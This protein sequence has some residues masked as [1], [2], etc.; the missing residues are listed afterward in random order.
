MLDISQR[1]RAAIIAHVKNTGKKR[2]MQQ[3]K[4]GNK[5]TG[6]GGIAKANPEHRLRKYVNKKYGAK[7]KRNKTNKWDIDLAYGEIF[8]EELANILGSKKIEVKTERDIWKDKGNIAI[9]IRSRGKD[10]GILTTKSEYWCH[11]LTV[12]EKVEGI[13]IMPTK[14]M[15]NKIK[16]MR[17]KGIGRLEKGGDNNTSILY[18]MP[19]K[20]LF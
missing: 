18:L 8:E 16:K 5:A 1:A 11:I 6:G 19:L 4:L 9:E 20:E 10:S 3:K 14:E 17:A 12:E 7:M 13:I 2:I 15:K